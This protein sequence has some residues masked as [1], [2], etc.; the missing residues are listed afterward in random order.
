MPDRP[1]IVVQT[2]IVPGPDR[3]TTSHYEIHLAPDTERNAPRTVLE[4][5]DEH[6]YVL[7]TAAE[8]AGCRVTATWHSGTRG[9]RRVYLLDTLE[10]V[11]PNPREKGD[12]DG[13]EYADPRDARDGR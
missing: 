3:L 13:V 12:D 2:F 6:A 7:A 5:R 8:N 4:T 10:I 1:L 11:A 9:G